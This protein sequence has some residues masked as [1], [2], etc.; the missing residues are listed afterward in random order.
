MLFR[1][2]SSSKKIFSAKGVAVKF[3]MISGFSGMSVLSRA[4]FVPFGVFLR[5][6]ISVCASGVSLGNVI[7]KLR[8]VW[9][10]LSVTLSSLILRS[11]RFPMASCQGSSGVS[12]SSQ[13]TQPLEVF[14]P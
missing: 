13:N 4:I 1:H 7:A 9:A 5:V 14:C 6:W 12:C 3:L 11:C 2:G 10:S 8:K